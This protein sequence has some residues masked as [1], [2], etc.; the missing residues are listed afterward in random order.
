MIDGIIGFESEL[1]GCG[2][3]SEYALHFDNQFNAIIMKWS[4]NNKIHK[5]N[6]KKYK[7]SCRIYRTNVPTDCEYSKCKTAKN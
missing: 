4:R 7:F 3:F 6:A 2:R 1:P 5:S